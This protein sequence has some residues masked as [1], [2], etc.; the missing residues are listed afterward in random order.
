MKVAFETLSSLL[1]DAFAYEAAFSDMPEWRRTRCVALRLDDDRRR[2]VAA[3][4]LLSRTLGEVGLPP[5]GFETVENRY[6]KVDLSPR[7]GLHFSLSHSAE[8]VMVALAECPVGCDVE[9][10]APADMDIARICCTPDEFALIESLDGGER[11]R[12]FVKSWVRRESLLKAIGCGFGKEV[13]P[14]H[15]LPWRVPDW[16]C[17]D[18][19]WGD[20]CL[21]AVVFQDT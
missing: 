11:D 1:P 20:A 7:Y 21:G 4:K 13:P 19:D 5:S 15:V 17:L 2:C 9:E 10:I 12:A 8:H 14:F 3:W 6:G 16:N 18:Y